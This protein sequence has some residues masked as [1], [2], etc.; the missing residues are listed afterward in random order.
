MSR[1]K[2]LFGS[3]FSYHQAI[4]TMNA[5][6][7]NNIPS[8]ASADTCASAQGDFTSEI[9]DNGQIDRQTAAATDRWQDRNR[10]FEIYATNSV[11]FPASLRLNARAIAEQMCPVEK[12]NAII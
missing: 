11:D 10:D 5:H 4:F 7:G 2:S 6:F 8:K 9:H 3:V 12:K 1:D